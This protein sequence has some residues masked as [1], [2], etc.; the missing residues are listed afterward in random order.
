MKMIAKLKNYLEVTGS[1]VLGLDVG[2]YSVKAVQLNKTDKKYSIAKLANVKI[3]HENNSKSNN[4]ADTIK[5]IHECFE[6]LEAKVNYTVAAVNGPDVIVR[7]FKLKPTPKHEV[8]AAILHEVEQVSPLDMRQSIIDYQL[9]GNLDEESDVLGLFVAA[10]SDTVY[11]INQCVS[12]AGLQNVL[13]DVNALAVLNC[14]LE[15]SDHDKNET[16]AVL[17]IGNAFSNLM[18]LPKDYRP[19]VRCIAHGTKEIIERVSREQTMSLED[20][21]K[22]L[23]GKMSY[24]DMNAFENSFKIAMET[25]INEIKETLLYYTSHINQCKIGKIYVC[26]GL[27]SAVGVEHLLKEGLAET[28]EVWNPLI[29]AS[30]AQSTENI[31][32]KIKT[33]PSMATAIGLAMREI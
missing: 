7:T 13:M 1:S 14:F 4:K 31:E 24:S 20:V 30:F 33:G 2:T 18:I 15:F 9:F 22:I 6:I 16:N 21:E 17:D 3:V 23:A 12:N 29:K 26:G 11:K 28:I 8:A 19:F 25:L 32:E 10:H 27:V 5:A